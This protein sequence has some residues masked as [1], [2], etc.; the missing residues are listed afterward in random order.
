VKL[1]ALLLGAGLVAAASAGAARAQTPDSTRAA[2]DSG[3][4][5]FL[6]CPNLFC[7]FDYYRTEITFVNWVRE[8]QDA[9]V[10]LL[11]TSQETGGGR[12]F[13]LG[14]IGLERFAGAADTLRHISRSTDSDD[15]IRKGLARMM[16]LGLVRFAAKTPLAPKIEISYSAPASAAAAVKDRWN[17]WVFNAGLSSFVQGEQSQK[18]ANLNVSLSA[19]RV[20]EAWKIRLSTNAS[21]RE[22]KFEF[23][24]DS[25]TTVTYR[26]LQ[27]GY[28]ARATIARS[29]GARWSAGGRV[30]VSRETFLNQDLAFSAGPVL[31]YD[32]VPYSQS[33]RRLIT[34]QFAPAVATFDYTDT[35]VFDKTAETLLSQTLTATIDVKEP[36]G[37]IGTS[38]EAAAYVEDLAKHH[39]AISA[40]AD[41]RLV[42]GLSLTLFGSAARIKDRIS[43]AKLAG[44]TPEE[45]LLQRRQLETDFQY[46]AF[47]QLRF[48]F[49]SKFANVVNP[50]LQEPNFF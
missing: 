33:T 43:V 18:F 34:L 48:T 11:I 31:E 14:F 50:R 49:G 10:H 45:V 24:Q 41:V 5:V 27:R 9:Q 47:I 13:T 26:N 39:V 28:Q 2:Q 21:Y 38:L 29:L 30:S 16:R 19:N 37:S 12:E 4:R 35:T 6:D 7:D 25:V 32:F 36:W 3:L 8:R 22:S 46:F 17:F 20:T 42:K 40:S 44:A 23:Q 1:S 15:D